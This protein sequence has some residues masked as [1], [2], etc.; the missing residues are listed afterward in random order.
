[1][2]KD[3]KFEDYV[4]LG[5]NALCKEMQISFLDYFKYLLDS[6]FMDLEEKLKTTFEI[7]KFENRS[8]QEVIEGILPTSLND[9][10]K[11]RKNKNYYICNTS[12]LLAV[13]RKI[14]SKDLYDGLNNCDVS[15]ISLYNYEHILK[16]FLLDACELENIYNNS[17]KC[18]FKYR[19]YFD[20]RY[21]PSMS[22][23]QILRQS[24]FGQVSMDSFADMEI[25]ASIAVIR[26]LIEL[27]IRRAFGVL[28]YIDEGKNLIPL[29]LS[30]LFQ[31][32]EKHK[33]DIQ[34]PVDLKSIERIYKWSN[35]YIHSGKGDFSWIPYFINEY[36]KDF[37]FGKMKNN[38]WDVNNGICTTQSTIDQIHNELTSLQS[39]KKVSI[40]GC[41]P[42]CQII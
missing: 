30:S 1:M 3:I 18:D 33:K 23:H 24:L 28:A 14:F 5:A 11:K 13:I 25:S 6:D 7:S 19:S 12:C 15:E 8:D 9:L 2:K 20:S 35:M 17:I 21:V 26:Q 32:L 27:R 40:Y 31:C 10:E 4:F 34:F 29:D 16:W 22:I 37:S 38:S 41:K 36:L 39:T 42:E